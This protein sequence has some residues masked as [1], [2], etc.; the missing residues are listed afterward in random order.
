MS[1]RREV[2]MS[3][4]R[5][6]TMGQRPE[7]V[8]SRRL[9]ALFAPDSVAVVGASQA[10]AK[11]G[12][13][14]SR[15]ALAGRATRR[16]HLVNRRGGELDGV[17]FAPSLAAVG[18]PVE[19]VVVAVPPESF[20]STVD[21]A[22]AVGA[23]A[24]VGVTAGLPAASVAQVAQRV[25]AA[26]AV[27]LGPN[28]MGV[29]DAATDLRLLWGDLPAGQIALVSQS[30][31]L[32]LELGAI[33]ARGGLGF[34]RF[35]S[36]GDAADVSA[37]ELLRA[38]TRHEGTRSI[39]L[40]LESV[41]DG[42]ALL[43]AAA[44]AVAAGQPVALLA[45]GASA[46]GAR[47]AHSH[48][49]ALATDARVLAA[50]CRDAGIIV[51]DTPTALIE[52]TRVSALGRWRPAGRR[53]G[54]VGDGGGHG[55]VAADL[56][57]AANLDVVTFSP[58][59]TA[60]LA[61]HLPATA[62]TANPVD[63]A[64]GGERDLTSY[65]RVVEAVAASGE[66][67][68]VLLTG[69]FGAY[70]EQDPALA[71]TEARVAD[72][73][74]A[75]AVPVFTHTIAPASATADRLRAAGVPVWSAVEH[76]VRA[77]AAVA[78]PLA[79]T[80]PPAPD[81]AMGVH[82]AAVRRQLEAAGV[83]FAR[84][85]PA[86]ALDEAQRAASRLGYPVVLKVAGL[87]HKSDV[88]GVALEL[89]QPSA[90]AAAWAAMTARLG[91]DRPYTVEEMLDARDGIEMIVGTRRDPSFGPVVVVGFGGVLAELIDDTA[92]ALAPVDRATAQSMVDRLRG[93]AL[94]RG[95][96]GRPPVD[97]EA[98]L[99]VVVAVSRVPA[100]LDLNP[101]LVRPCGAVVLDL[102][103]AEGLNVVGGLNVA[104]GVT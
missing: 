30:G 82:K 45:A 97:E 69:Y 57:T 23:R 80:A 75:A 42:R 34:S 63:L 48:T 29:Y 11:W 49:G 87:A 10:P 12:Y 7:V 37:V 38:V 43:A 99:D 71:A 6:V 66:V 33:A 15:G 68:A 21:E 90:L 4:R 44:E 102:H 64:G 56:A 95:Y 92:V 5:E 26:G 2:A 81:L 59:L 8:V 54:I 91:A 93:A 103:V 96:R 9:E 35:A 52:A 50:A 19:L 3:Q 60:D 39:A 94:L 47:A 22:L 40:Y 25:R 24:V 67:D 72:A 89:A 13:H 79:I 53:L 51:V 55:I 101:V 41:G 61:S 62:A 31:N 58:G 16:V 70:A 100:E 1:Q 65:A 18:E 76:A 74:G 32:A 28:C 46:V 98:L 14:L 85:M 88:G 17:A 20:T 27:L 84:S 86:S 36:L 77:V 83:R 104:G 73:I 78:Q